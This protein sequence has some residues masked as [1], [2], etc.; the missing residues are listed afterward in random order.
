MWERCTTTTT[1]R[2]W[3]TPAHFVNGVR[4][5]YAGYRHL[6]FVE[7][8]P[9]GAS[10]ERDTTQAGAVALG[11]G[12]YGT[13]NTLGGI[14]YMTFLT[15]FEGWYHVWGIDEPSSDRVRYG[16]SVRAAMILGPVFLDVTAA[17]DA[18]FGAEISLGAG[19]LLGS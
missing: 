14:P 5:V 3:Q 7:G 12:F 9:T 4:Y 16:G 1:T 18:G 10:G 6:G 17:L 11:I 15:E 2:Q 13:K 19:V 8:A